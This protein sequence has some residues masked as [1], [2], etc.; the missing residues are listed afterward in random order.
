MGNNQQ[1]YIGTFHPDQK[2]DEWLTQ[3]YNAREPYRLVY[4][5]IIKREMGFR[6]FN[7]VMKIYQRN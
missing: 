2:M 7:D 6:E 3:M 4:R 1:E 5:W